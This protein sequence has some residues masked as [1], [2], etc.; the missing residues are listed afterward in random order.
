MEWLHL[1]NLATL[2]QI[3]ED[4]KKNQNSLLF[5]KHSTRCSISKMALSRIETRFLTDSKITPYFL[6]LLAY[7]DISN[8]IAQIFNVAHQSPQALV[9]KNGKC[10]YTASHGDINFTEILNSII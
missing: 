4:S 8:E 10:I 1:T 5:F 2:H 7:R 3:V 9:V 6:D